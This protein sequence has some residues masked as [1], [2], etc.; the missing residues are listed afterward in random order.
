[1]SQLRSIK[2]SYDIIKSQDEN[3][4]I[5]AHTIRTWCKEGKIKCLPYRRQQDSRRY[6]LSQR[7]RRHN[8]QRA[9]KVYSH[10]IPRHARQSNTS[11]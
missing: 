3:T 7:V 11:P 9:I 10:F 4:A 8:K 1:M 5:T 6:R 2:A